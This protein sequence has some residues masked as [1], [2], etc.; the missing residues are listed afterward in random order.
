M[1][2]KIKELYLKYEEIIVYL[3]VGVLTTV[4]S[5]VACFVCELF[6]DSSISWQNFI[7]NSIGWVVGVVFAYPL[8]RLVGV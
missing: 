2:A 7:T 8:N 4:V 6:L 5:W 1:T 3:I